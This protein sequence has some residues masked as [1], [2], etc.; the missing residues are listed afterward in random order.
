MSKELWNN[1]FSRSEFVYGKEPNEFFKAEIDK[2]KPGKLYLPGEGEGRN[3]VY[4][5]KLGWDVLAA[6]QSEEGR[7]KA[8]LLAEEEHVTIKYDI[9]D[10]TLM[11]LPE[12]SFD[13]ITLIFIHLN[14]EQRH[15]YHKRLCNAL[16]PG[17]MI[18]MEAF[19]KDQL[20]FK[21]GGPQDPDMLYTSSMLAADFSNMEIL[22][23][24]ETRVF[25]NEGQ[26]HVGEG[27]VVRFAVRRKN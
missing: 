13:L 12:K 4:A 27:A 16:K 24:E 22:M 5:A 11:D 9:G 26:L 15:A 10:I 2:L 19:T 17:G 1:R 8:L 18:I 7:N 3:A 20:N 21:S 14:S 23:N 25:L 6:D